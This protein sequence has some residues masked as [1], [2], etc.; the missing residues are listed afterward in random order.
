M[1][2]LGA[3]IV[4]WAGA[5]ALLA[6]YALLSLGRIPHS[7]RYQVLNLAGSAGLALNGVVHQAWPSAVLNLLW[8]GIGVVALGRLR[9]TRLREKSGH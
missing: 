5:A 9:R 8:V 3:E 7:G 1:S 2:T 6:G 4:G